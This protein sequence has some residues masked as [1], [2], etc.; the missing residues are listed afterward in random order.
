MKHSILHYERLA[1]IFA[2]PR[3]GYTGRVKERQSF[4][5][6]YLPEAGRLLRPFTGYMSTLSLTAQE[7][8]FLR[9][10]EVQAVT[11]LDLGY[12]LF[13]DDYKRGALLVNL[14]REHRQAQNDCGT[15][16]ADHLSNV[17][18]LLPKMQDEQIVEEL[19]RRI[20]APALKRMIRGFGPEQIKLKDKFYKKKH[21]TVIDRPADNH[22]IYVKALEALYCLLKHDFGIEERKLPEE[23]SDFLK[24]LN[25]EI[26]LEDE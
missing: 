26:K 11:T 16:L 19:V 2:Y 8:L 15:E 25:T 12:V 24:N 20:V 23:V 1:D 5:D 21:Q 7:E 9:S 6:R 4:L 18:R 10:F 17:L 14:N 3:E 13:G 22:T